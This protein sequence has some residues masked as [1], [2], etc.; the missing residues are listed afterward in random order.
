[1]VYV[2]QDGQNG[3]NILCN[4]EHGCW[5][6]SPNFTPLNVTSPISWMIIHKLCRE[7]ERKYIRMCW[8]L[9]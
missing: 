4:N 9:F 6:A 8:V 2:L 1:M 7:R 5:F 3:L